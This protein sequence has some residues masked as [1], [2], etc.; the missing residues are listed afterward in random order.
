LA[1]ATDCDCFRGEVFSSTIEH[2]DKKVARRKK[3]SAES[4]V[5]R[6]LER[7]LIRLMPALP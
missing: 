7:D 6:Q 2:G 1:F 5:E 3:Q 4:N